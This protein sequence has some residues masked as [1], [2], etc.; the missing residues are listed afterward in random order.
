VKSIIVRSSPVVAL[1]LT[2]ARVAA[3]DEKPVDS[4]AV[5]KQTLNERGNTTISAMKTTAGREI[6]YCPD[7]TCDIF[8]APSSTPQSALADFAFTYIYYA[9]GY[10]YLRDF[11]T[12]TGRPFSNVILNRNHSACTEDEEFDSASCVLRSLAHRYSIRVLFVRDDEGTRSEV[13]VDIESA[14]NI[15]ELR[16]MRAWQLE[17]WRS[18]P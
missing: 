11:V 13:P 15:D 1:F 8:K 3:G 6:H 4:L 17:Q 5:L 12:K 9:S 16:R 10:T 2:L 18:H 7:N 14:A